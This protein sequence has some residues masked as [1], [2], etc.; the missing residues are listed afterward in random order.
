MKNQ[1][2]IRTIICQG[3]GKV[4]TKRMPRGRKYCSSECY[5]NSLRPQRKT[6]KIIKC[7]WCGK[8]IY[9]QKSYLNHKH[10]FCSI[11]CANKWQARNKKTFICKVCGKKFRL[12]K[13]LAEQKGRNPTYCS[14]ACREKDPEYMGHINGNLVQ[15]HKKGLNKLELTGRKILQ[16]LEIEF[17]E[18]ILMFNKFLVDVLL[19]NKKIIIQWDG[20]YWHSKPERKKLDISQDAYLKKCGYE[21]LRFTDKDIKNNK[22]KVI[23]NIKRA[24]Q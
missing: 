12:S 8:E 4:I 14:I 5:R 18:Q 10:Y 11:D 15:Q 6:G 3:C 21:V 16:D 24:I 20:V 9:K 7:E 22:E 1:Y 13:S 17:N 2:K 19:K 23:E